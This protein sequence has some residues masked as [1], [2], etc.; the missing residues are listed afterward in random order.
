MTDDEPV[1][2]DGRVFR[3]ATNEGEVGA[4]TRMAFEQD[5][6]VVTC[7]YAGGEVRLGFLVGTLDG[8][9][10]D[11]RY[12]QLNAAGE[13][14]TGHSVGLVERLDD[15]RLR[16]RDVWEW[17]SREGHGSTVLEEVEE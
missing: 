3:A 12:V 14:A 7:R 9:E 4:E 10:L 5:G 15:G 17:E 8:R 2:L 6:D 13:T 16:I 11:S 1:S